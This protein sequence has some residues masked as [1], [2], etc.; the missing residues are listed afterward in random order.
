[1]D[2]A[3]SSNE[4]ENLESNLIKKGRGKQDVNENSPRVSKSVRNKERFEEIDREMQAKLMEIQSLMQE[5]GL[6]GS[7]DMVANQM[8][9]Q[10][11]Q[12]V[13]R[14]SNQGKNSN[15]N[16]SGVIGK[17][18]NKGNSLE[19]GEPNS[20]ETIYNRAVQARQ[21][22]RSSS[23]DDQVDTSDE[24]LAVGIEGLNMLSPKITGSYRDQPREE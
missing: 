5:G 21:E 2:D 20:E 19:V 1:M 12:A 4:E 9:P 3:E 10:L 23:D 16:S 8:I 17:K 24:L 13:K 18:A 22:R 14:K 6:Y 11:Q 7:M 15:V